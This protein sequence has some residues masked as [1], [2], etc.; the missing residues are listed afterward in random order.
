MQGRE[1]RYRF[2]VSREVHADVQEATV[3]NIDLFVEV[4]YFGEGDLGTAHYEGTFELAANG[5]YLFKGALTLGDGAAPPPQKDF[6]ELA[7]IDGASDPLT[8]PSNERLLVYAL[9]GLKAVA[10]GS[11]TEA[12]EWLEFMLSNYKDTPEKR[13]LRRLL[14]GRQ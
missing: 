12:R 7:N 5:N 14:S 3:K 4:N 6:E 13:T 8:S 11:N 10:V 1:L 2:G 9:P